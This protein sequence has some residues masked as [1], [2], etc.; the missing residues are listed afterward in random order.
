M[1]L[2]FIT[3]EG[4]GEEGIKRE[5]LLLIKECSTHTDRSNGAEIQHTEDAADGSGAEEGGGG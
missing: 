5:K 1:P 2:S 3:L 4:R